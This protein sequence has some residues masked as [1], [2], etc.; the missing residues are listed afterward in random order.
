MIGPE[1]LATGER[2]EFA[3]DYVAA[4]AAYRAVSVVGDQS[5]AAEA[6]FR[7]GR[8]DWKQGRFVA[9]LSAF[10]NARAL[11]ARMADAELLAR[12]D[13]GIGA[14][15]YAVGEYDLARQAYG[16]A[17]AATRDVAMRGK[18]VLNLGVI[19]NIRGDMSEALAHYERAYVMFAECGDAASATLALHNRGMVQADLS[20]WDAADE[21]FR[22][23]LERAAACGDRELT[24]RALVNR[25]EVL[26]ERLA[27]EEAIEHCDRALVIY[28]DVSDDVG[29][30]EALRRRA[31]ALLRAARL[32]DALV[33]AQEAMR[34][35]VRT[36]ARLLEAES[37]REL[38]LIQLASGD[39]ARAAKQLKRS[40]ALFTRLGAV[41]EADEV[42]VLLPSSS[43]SRRA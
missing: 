20:L 35:A 19:E 15:H 10:E 34:I 43:P 23:V 14:V 27:L 5:L 8:V 16:R 3:G 11:A 7:L 28:Q 29:R 12:I 21:S 42:R 38:G 4:A 39:R 31:C 40:L 17:L 18:I 33:D 6:H 13:N 2:A 30:G 36:G 26:I 24:A 25:T 32:G 37:A 9:S 41:R 22:A 1:Q